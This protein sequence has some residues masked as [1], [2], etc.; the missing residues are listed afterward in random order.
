MK[1]KPSRL[2]G[3]N[4]VA[5]ELLPESKEDEEWL[6]DLW[7]IGRLKVDESGE[8]KTMLSGEWIDEIMLAISQLRQEI[9]AKS[10]KQNV[11]GDPEVDCSYKDSGPCINEMKYGTCHVKKPKWIPVEHFSMSFSYDKVTVEIPDP[12]HKFNDLM[13]MPANENQKP[14]LMFVCASFRRSAET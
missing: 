11:Y 5:L 8:K 2:K 3:V 12:D 10:R 13:I 9:E 14:L 1:C 7:A 4:E 6:N